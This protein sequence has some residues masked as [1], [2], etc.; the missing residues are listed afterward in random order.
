[1]VVQI[2]KCIVKN[3]NAYVEFG[4]K[5]GLN[6]MTSMAQQPAS[7]KSVRVWRWISAIHLSEQI[8]VQPDG[9]IQA[10]AKTGYW[11]KQVLLSGLL[12]QCTASF[13]IPDTRWIAIATAAVRI[14]VERQDKTQTKFQPSDICPNIRGADFG[15]LSWRSQ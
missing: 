4:L 13:S 5:G 9:Y 11:W 7:I 10:G 1:L 2:T 6:V 8:A 3:T 12:Y 15:C 14:I